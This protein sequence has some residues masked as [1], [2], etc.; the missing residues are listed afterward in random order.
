[1]T[2]TKS[3]CPECQKEIEAELTKEDGKIQITKTCKDHGTFIATHWQSPKV[4]DFTEKYDFFKY[5]E[6]SDKVSE[7]PGCPYSC[8]SCNGHVSDTVIGVIDVTKQCVKRMFPF[9]SIHTSSYSFPGP[10]E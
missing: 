2:K 1:M 8:E 5:F 9:E 6:E 10:V 3:I 4:Y 7:V